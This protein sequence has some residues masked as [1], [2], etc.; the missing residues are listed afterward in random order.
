MKRLLFYLQENKRKNEL[1]MIYM[2]KVTLHAWNERTP[3]ITIRLYSTW[4]YW[5][6]VPF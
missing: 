2:L 1:T 5:C 4:N 6:R 3:A